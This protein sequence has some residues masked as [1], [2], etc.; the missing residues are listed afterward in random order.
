[1]YKTK[2]MENIAKQIKKS[3][4][5]SLDT[6]YLDKLAYEKIVV[7]KS[8]LEQLPFILRIVSIEAVSQ[9]E[10]TRSKF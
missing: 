7:L 3:Y 4:Q 5:I 10:I 8:I 6:T 9:K 1:M 2:D